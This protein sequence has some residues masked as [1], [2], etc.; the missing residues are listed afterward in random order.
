[1][2]STHNNNEF[3]KSDDH[4]HEPDERLK[5]RESYYFN[6]ID[7]ESGISGFSTLGIV[8]NEKKREFVFILFMD[9]KREVYYREPDLAEYSKEKFKQ[10]LSDKKLSYQL[11]EPLKE[12]SINYNSRKYK[13]KINF[14]NRHRPYYFGKDSSASW[15]RHFESSGFITGSLILRNGDEIEINGFGQRDKSWGYRDWHE[16]E[17][18]YAGHFQ[19]DNWAA[20]F[21][22]DYIHGNSE[23]SGYIW[24]GNKN[25]PLKEVKTDVKYDDDSFNS[26]LTTEYTLI[27]KEGNRYDIKAE[28][29]ADNSF[30]RFARDFEDGFTEL[31]EQMVKMTNIETGEVGTGMSEE[32]RTKIS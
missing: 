4:L 8:P 11:V 1:M 24:N 10:M 15:H 25:I 22:K 5:W 18:W 28:R 19:F 12:W 31:F 30:I 14:K 16:F 9:N 29:I 26:P 23:V 7:I 6:W 27:D 13:F 2:D 32:L 17:K 3:N 20:G 21:R